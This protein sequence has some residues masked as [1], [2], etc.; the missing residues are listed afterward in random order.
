MMSLHRLAGQSAWSRRGTLLWVVVSVALSTLLMLSIERLRADARQ[1]FRQAVSGTDLIIGPRTGS[2]E[3]L[4]YTVFRLGAAT[5]TISLRSVDK[6]AQHPSVAWVV[7]LSLGDSHRGFAVLG[8]RSNY[9]QHFHYGDRQALRCTEGRPFDEGAG[10]LF[11]ATLGSEVA[12]RLGYRIGQAITLQHGTG[13]A[14]STDHA[15]KPFRVVGILAPTGTPVD[16]TVHVSLESLTAIHLDWMGGAP[17]PGLRI[18]ADQVR[19]FN[20]VPEEVTAALVGLKNRSAVFNVQ[21]QV[22]QSPDEALMAILPGVALDELWGIL[23]LGETAL[24]GMSIMVALVSLVGLM[25][26][27]LAGLNERRRELAVLRAIGASPRH[28]ALLVG[29]EGLWITLL[30]LGLGIILTGLL[31]A[32]LAPWSQTQ[33]G[34]SL[35]LWPPTPSQM[36]VLMGVMLAGLTASALPAWR[37]YRYALADG[38]SPTV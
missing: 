16:R 17:L 10:G 23:A 27:V 38:L 12:E 8:T 32:G 31:I 20:L 7:P 24:L 21:R 22:A 14:L 3:L 1:S 36:V 34:I 26:V 18:P 30:G 2:I 29:L 37:A 19:K 9:F 4:L 6:L 11:E 13:G 33:H 15:D 25:A 35:Q 28:I 5:N